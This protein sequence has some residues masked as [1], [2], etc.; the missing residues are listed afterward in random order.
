M[1]DILA[2]C[3][4]TRAASSN[5]NLIHAIADL[6]RDRY[7]IRIY[8]GLTALPQ[9]DPDKDHAHPPAEVVALRRQLREAEGVLICTPEYAM[10]VP[11]ALKNAIDWTVSSMEF[12]KRPVALITASLAGERAHRSLL[13]TLLIIESRM[14]VDSQLVISSVRSKMGSDATITD[15]ATLNGVNKLIR[16][17]EEMIANKED[18]LLSAPILQNDGLNSLGA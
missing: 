6:A 9:F 1:Y 17:L 16:S 18:A 12:S 14:T 4:S 11:G 13:G 2:I 15:D 3:G 8:G 7:T 10:G 5:L